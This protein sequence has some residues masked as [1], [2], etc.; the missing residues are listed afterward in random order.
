MN[1]TI[2]MT[3]ANR[4]ERGKHR[5]YLDNRGGPVLEGSSGNQ[6]WNLSGNATHRLL[7]EKNPQNMVL[8]DGA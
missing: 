2:K 6:D 3:V 5:R 7:G 8:V 4:H 1:T